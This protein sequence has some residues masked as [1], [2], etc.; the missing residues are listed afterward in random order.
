MTTSGPDLLVQCGKPGLISLQFANVLP[1]LGLG[2]QRNQTT[3]TTQG[4]FGAISLFELAFM[5]GVHEVWVCS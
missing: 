2:T 3:A 5:V 1:S 4:S